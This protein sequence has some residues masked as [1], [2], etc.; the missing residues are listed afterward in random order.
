MVPE[1]P[2]QFSYF[3]TFECAL[4]K[5]HE[6][7]VLIRHVYAEYELK[8][9]SRDAGYGRNPTKSRNSREYNKARALSFLEDLKRP[10]L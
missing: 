4:L 6:D 9:G 10:S 8:A 5:E 3:Y 1:I 2:V 7:C